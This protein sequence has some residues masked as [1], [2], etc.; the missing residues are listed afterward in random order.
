MFELLRATVF[1]P[2]GHLHSRLRRAAAEGGPLPDDLATF[3]EKVRERAST[4]TDEDVAA[5]RKAGHDDDTIFEVV[6]SAAVGAANVRYA[7]ARR[8]IGED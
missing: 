1:G 7:A 2:N 6:V 3:A 4:V 8:A 5:L